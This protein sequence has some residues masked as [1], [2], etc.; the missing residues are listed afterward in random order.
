MAL[1]WSRFGNESSG[2]GKNG[3]EGELRT[4]ENNVSLFGSE[5]LLGGEKGDYSKSQPHLEAFWS[6]SESPPKL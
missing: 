4:E 3:R 6:S 2:S 5:E 1:N